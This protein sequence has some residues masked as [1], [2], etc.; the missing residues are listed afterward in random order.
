MY[1]TFL[2]VAI[3]CS[4]QSLKI[5]TTFPLS[6]GASASKHYHSHSHHS[7]QQQQ[8]PPPPTHLSSSPQQSSMGE[9]EYTVL[10]ASP[11]IHRQ[12]PNAPLPPPPSNA[13]PAGGGG[14]S[15]SSA[16]H[17]SVHQLHHMYGKCYW[18]A[19]RCSYTVCSSV[20]KSII[21]FVMVLS[22]TWRLVDNK[23]LLSS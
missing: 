2:A 18:S 12:Y 11:R 21:T 17:T 5:L 15:G 20:V 14:G 4:L 3:Q 19:L 23:T 13:L 1:S 8:P 16:H 7:Q 6:Q 10:T 9:G 22:R